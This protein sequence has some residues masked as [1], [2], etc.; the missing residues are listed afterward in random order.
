MASPSIHLED[1]LALP[2]AS[3]AKFVR[4]RRVL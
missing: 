1:D 3:F 2:S 4:P